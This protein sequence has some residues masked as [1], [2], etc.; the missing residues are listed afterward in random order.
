MLL[1]FSMLFPPVYR[2]ITRLEL[3]KL[4]FLISYRS[5]PR[6]HFQML[7]NPLNAVL[8][9]YSTCISPNETSLNILQIIRVK[10]VQMK[11]IEAVE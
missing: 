8:L 4:Y 3:R 2:A 11:G 5:N 7:Q 6:T 9:H 10:S 1:H